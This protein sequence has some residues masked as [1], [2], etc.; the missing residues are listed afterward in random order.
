[1]S[2]LFAP[3]IMPLLNDQCFL[4]PLI[5]DRVECA[6]DNGSTMLLAIW[7][8]NYSVGIAGAGVGYAHITGMY[9][10]YLKRASNCAC[11]SIFNDIITVFGLD[12]RI[13]CALWHKV[14]S[15]SK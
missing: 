14:Q 5:P 11:F 13:F 3:L 12:I 6:G 1:M 4:E 9:H 15:R 10:P 2:S 8:Q 7:K